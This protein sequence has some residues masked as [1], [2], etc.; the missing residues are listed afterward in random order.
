[1]NQVMSKTKIIKSKRQLPNLKSLLVKSEFQGNLIPPSV[2]KCKEPRCGLCSYLIEGNSLKLKNKTFHVKESMTCTVQNVLYVLVCN[3]CN[4][5][6]IGQTGDKL[7]NRKTVHLQ[8]VRDPSTRQLPV[9]EH[10]DKCTKNEPK[11][12]IFPFYIFHNSDASARLLKES[13]FVKIFNPK[14]NAAS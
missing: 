6:Y 1:M 3:G 4:E 7:R 12:S 5:F 10:L 9:S 2:K 8:Q 13:Y 11:F 14:L